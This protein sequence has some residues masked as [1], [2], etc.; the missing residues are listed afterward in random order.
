MPSAAPG[1][2]SAQPDLAPAIP[3]TVDET[4]VRRALL[5]ELALKII[6]LEGELNLRQLAA[7]MGLAA[8]VVEEIFQRLR[9]AQFCEVAGMDGSTY[10][11]TA[12]AAGRARAQELLSRNQYAGIAPVSLDDYVARVR[13]QSIGGTPV[14]PADV[15]RAFDALVL[16][17]STLRQ[18]GIAV[19]SG[20]SMVLYGPTGTGKTAIAERIP[21]IFD[22]QG[23]WIPHAVEVD[24]Q[25]ITV[26][27]E[28]VHRRIEP[29]DDPRAPAAA[30]GAWGGVLRAAPGQF[31][32]ITPDPRWVLCERPRV[33]VGGELTIEM[34]D[35]QFNPVTGF[36]TAPLQ[37][38]ANDGLLILDDFG[39]QRIGPEELLNRWIVPLD[40][41]VDFLTLQGGKKFEIP[42]GLLVVF[43]TNLDPSTGFSSERQ[44]GITDQAFL[45][46]I[47]NKVR[48][49]YVTPAQFHEVFRRACGEF[50]VLYDHV[51]VE[52]LVGH[53]ETVLRQPL[54]PCYPRDI[55]QQLTW[56]A[57][58]EG[59]TPQLRW[60]AVDRACR[61]Y[62][63]ETT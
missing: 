8:P 14:T 59:R 36:Y 1:Q 27:D 57:R 24:G 10:R 62:F 18:L 60:D 30:P 21:R 19:L 12:G 40:R 23:V 41:R 47:P 42:F 5:E 44:A 49:G 54:R 56:E 13:R 52:Q 22:H 58:Y 38:K 4:G 33:V 34:L 39:R 63:L 20:T 29:L 61:T 48:V 6:Y 37:M 26:F 53:L 7:R 55:L 50:G 17:E 11:V 2:H 45:R 9:R 43:S 51:V 25:I 35:L 3:H 31:G 32:A 15:R 28:H 46:R 16:G